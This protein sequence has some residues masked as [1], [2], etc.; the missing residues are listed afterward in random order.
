[1]N[2]FTTCTYLSTSSQYRSLTP[3]Y[4]HLLLKT[5]NKHDE[6]K[7]H[8]HT[9]TRH[10]NKYMHTCSYTTTQVLFYQYS[11]AVFRIMLWGGGATFAVFHSGYYMNVPSD[12]NSYHHPGIV[13]CDHEYSHTNIPVLCCLARE[14]H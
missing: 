13:K 9:Q 4:T 7:D 12:A 8:M 3:P 5:H 6:K 1:M 10:L 2:S 14:C 11:A